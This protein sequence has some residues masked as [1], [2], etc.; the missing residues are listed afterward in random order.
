[1]NVTISSHVIHKSW[2]KF[3]S[4]DGFIKTIFPLF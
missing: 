3:A 1:M 4:W 2:H